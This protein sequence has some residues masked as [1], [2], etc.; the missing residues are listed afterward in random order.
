VDPDGSRT[1]LAEHVD[2]FADWVMY[3]YRDAERRSHNS[4]GCIYSWLPDSRFHL[5]RHG[6]VVVASCCS[7]R[8]FKFTP[9]TGLRA[10]NLAE[11]ILT[12]DGAPRAPAT[13]LRASAGGSV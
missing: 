7:G 13:P 12:D 8:G 2:R 1:P 6:R 11:D 10:A 9:L 4:V 3:R 5:Q